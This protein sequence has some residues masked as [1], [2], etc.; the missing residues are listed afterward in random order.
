VGPA[1]G[2]RKVEFAFKGKDGKVEAVA[3]RMVFIP[4]LE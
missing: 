3:W 4:G 2:P 1:S